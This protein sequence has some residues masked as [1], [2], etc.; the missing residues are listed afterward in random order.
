MPYNKSYYVL[1]NESNT[2]TNE[3]WSYLD[4]SSINIKVKNNKIE[5]LRQCMFSEKIFPMVHFTFPLKFN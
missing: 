2:I 3:V 1:L 4:S 5:K